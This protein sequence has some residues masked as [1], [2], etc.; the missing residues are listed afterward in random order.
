MD[1]KNTFSQ[2]HTFKDNGHNYEGYRVDQGADEILYDVCKDILKTQGFDFV[3]DYYH[4]NIHPNNP[5]YSHNPEWMVSVSQEFI[6]VSIEEENP[7]FL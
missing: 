3:D 4:E 1:E 2:H 6:D 5:D 7:F